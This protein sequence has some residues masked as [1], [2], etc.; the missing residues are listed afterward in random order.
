MRDDGEPPRI[1]VLEDE[2]MILLELSYALED[3]G[4]TPA[5]ATNVDAAFKLIED[6]PPDAAILDVNLGRNATCE[7]VADR[8]AE[9]GVPFLLHSGDLVRQGELIARIGAEVISK[10]A[11][12]HH[13]A[14]RAV[15]LARG[16]ALR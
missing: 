8:L 3:E 2:A 15:A 11:A 14:A 16:L 9:L 7:P 10:P 13:V 5:T 6:A 4:A 1:L 12:S